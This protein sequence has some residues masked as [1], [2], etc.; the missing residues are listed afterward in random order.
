MTG[1]LSPS[2]AWLTPDPQEGCGL[3]PQSAQP[4]ARSWLGGLDTGGG[5]R[6]CHLGFRHGFQGVSTNPQGLHVKFYVHAICIFP[7][8]EDSQLILKRT[9]HP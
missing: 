9:Y 4:A 7:Q 2:A 5:T 3:L 8:E 1:E 6:D